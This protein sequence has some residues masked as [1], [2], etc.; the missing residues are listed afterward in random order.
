MAGEALT[1]HHVVKIKTEIITNQLI[2]NKN[3]NKREKD[4]DEEIYLS[5]YLF[6]TVL[7]TTIRSYELA[8][9]Y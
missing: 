8:F 1:A 4:D 5:I 3:M 6:P 9:R 7:A 2:T